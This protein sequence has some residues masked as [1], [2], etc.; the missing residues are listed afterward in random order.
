MKTSEILRNASK[1]IAQPGKWTIR[2][3]ARDMYGDRVNYDSPL[4]Y[5]FCAL[6]AMCKFD[7][8]N[9]ALKKIFGTYDRLY[10]N[11]LFNPI[12][13]NDSQKSVWPVLA[14]LNAIAN[15]FEAEG[16]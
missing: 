1:L 14:K 9:E 13:D 5:S 7:I 6:G 16:D 3:S 11:T 4:A 8:K 15:K 10:S 2:A 12:V